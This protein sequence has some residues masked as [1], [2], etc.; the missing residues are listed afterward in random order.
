M[1]FTHWSIGKKVNPARFSSKSNT[2]AAAATDMLDFSHEQ[3]KRL[4]D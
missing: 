4:N 2:C 1:Q 3:K